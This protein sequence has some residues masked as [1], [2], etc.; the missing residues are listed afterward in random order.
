MVELHIHRQNIRRGQLRSFDLVRNSLGVVEGFGF[1]FEVNLFQST[2]F[3]AH[4]SLK[5]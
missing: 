5:E 1:R 3:C 2:N 4:N